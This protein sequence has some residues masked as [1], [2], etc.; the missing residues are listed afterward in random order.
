MV[1]DL[2]ESNAKT[3]ELNTVGSYN[4]IHKGCG[5]LETRDNGQTVSRADSI[6]LSFITD[7]E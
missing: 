2:P 3:E 4:T 7:G 6:F 5:E 1:D